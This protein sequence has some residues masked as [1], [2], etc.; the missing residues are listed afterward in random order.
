MIGCRKDISAES[1]DQILLA[2][3]VAMVGLESQQKAFWNGN[4]KSYQCQ[5]TN[6]DVPLSCDGEQHRFHGQ[7]ADHNLNNRDPFQRLGKGAS[8]LT[9]S[10]LVAM[11]MD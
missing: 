5:A 3:A 4:A 10:S 1:Q 11:D 6:L 2:G 7:L 8:I 9:A